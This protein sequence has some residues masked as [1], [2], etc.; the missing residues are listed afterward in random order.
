MKMLL[1][2]I[3][4]FLLGCSAP[5]AQESKDLIIELITNL[6]D[7]EEHM[8]CKGGKCCAPEEVF[9]F[10]ISNTGLDTV[11]LPINGTRKGK[12]I[13]AKNVVYFAES[14]NGDTLYVKSV[15]TRSFFSN[16][17]DSLPRG[18]S[19]YYCVFSNL[20]ILRA[21]MKD[22][23]AQYVFPYFKKATADS[24]F[25]LEALVKISEEK[26][27]VSQMKYPIPLNIS[28]GSSVRIG[29]NKIVVLK[30]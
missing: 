2:L 27:D 3:N 1:L 4:L 26:E 14:E 7:I 11:Y 28:S 24:T 5:K 25:F 8:P 16:H 22:D 15:A 9:L 29:K 17:F 20:F 21:E 23:Y 19:R 30:D 10:K 12:W 13:V 6:E 18:I